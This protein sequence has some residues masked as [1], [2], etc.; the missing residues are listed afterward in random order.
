[1]EQFVPSQVCGFS[2]SAGVCVDVGLPQLVVVLAV[3]PVSRPK[4]G[5]CRFCVS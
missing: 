1:M 3:P 2:P 5:T 4:R